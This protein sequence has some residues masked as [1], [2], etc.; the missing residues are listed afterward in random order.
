[1]F[2]LALK[3]RALANTV[4]SPWSE[5][6][7][8]QETDAE[9]SLFIDAGLQWFTARRKEKVDV[10][11]TIGWFYSITEIIMIVFLHEFYP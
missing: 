8:G 5:N 1:M 3:Q 6:E 7:D 11:L 10:F 4:I 9:V 2:V